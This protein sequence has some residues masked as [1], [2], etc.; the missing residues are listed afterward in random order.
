LN[1]KY[2]IEF[3]I[4]SNLIKFLRIL[5]VQTRFEL[6]YEFIRMENQ[7]SNC[8]FGLHLQ[9]PSPASCD[10]A[11]PTRPF[12]LTDR[13]NRGVDF[14]F[15]HQRSSAKI[16]PASGQRPVV[17]GLGTMP[18]RWGNDLRI[19][20]GRGLTDGDGWRR[21]TQAVEEACRRRGRWVA[22]VGFRPLED[23][24]RLLKLTMVLARPENDE[25]LLVL[26]SSSW[27]NRW[28]GAELLPAVWPLTWA[29]DRRQP[30]RTSLRSLISGWM[31]MS[32]RGGG[33]R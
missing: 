9:K 8:C 2:G 11:L 33:W 24:C 6:K 3:I 32:G 20:T 26:A 25:R 31:G 29:H 18:D 28:L 22:G 16:Q 30:K 13:G 19:W 4:L 12:W 27:R 17:N 1:S 7:K 10:E 15:P 5:E 14:P 21:L 23:R